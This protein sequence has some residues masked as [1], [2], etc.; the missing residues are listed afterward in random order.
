MKSLRCCGGAAVRA[1]LALKL[2]KD[3]TGVYLVDLCIFVGATHLR[4]TYSVQWQDV[5]IPVRY[6]DKVTRNQA[7]KQTTGKQLQGQQ[8]YK[9]I[10]SVLYH[11]VFYIYY[12][13]R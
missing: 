5:M 8:L 13:R 11:T 7:N 12:D 10:F 9:L 6:C 4:T 3:G 2:K 1:I